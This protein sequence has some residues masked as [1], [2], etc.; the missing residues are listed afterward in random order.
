MIGK[1]IRCAEIGSNFLREQKEVYFKRKTK[2]VSKNPKAASSTINHILGR[3]S[4][5]RVI[6]NI[7]LGGSK[8]ISADLMAEN[9]SDYF[10]RIGPKIAE[11]INQGEHHLD[12]YLKKVPNRFKFRIVGPS[13]VFH[14]LHSLSISK[15][16]GMNKIPAKVLKIAAPIITE[17]LTNIFNYAIITESFPFDWKIARVTPIHKNGRRDLLDNYLSISI[18]PIITKLLYEQLYEYLHSDN[19][20]L[21]HQ[22]GFRQRHFTTTALLD[23]TNEWF[24][25]ID[26]GLFNLVVFLDLQMK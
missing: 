10:T 26:Q 5:D 9:F 12:D 6:N 17:S 3:K 14:L 8:L 18:L 4:Q 24:T 2:K 16:T 23:C 20:I 13:E 22:F 7:K 21:E 19:L 25:N 1:L 15:A 11:G